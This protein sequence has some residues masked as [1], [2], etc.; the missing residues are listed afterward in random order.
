MPTN[1]NQSAKESKNNSK[2]PKDW[3]EQLILKKSSRKRA[4]QR[5]Y[6]TETQ[7]SGSS[8]GSMTYMK[9]TKLKGI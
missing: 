9:N 3:M 1:R 8:P 7:S 5:L 4:K 6:K 2:K